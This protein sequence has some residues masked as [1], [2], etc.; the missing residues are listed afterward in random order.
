[1]MVL[2]N[3]KISGKLCWVSVDIIITFKFHSQFFKY[4]IVKIVTFF[5]HI[6][7]IIKKDILTTWKNYVQ[8]MEKNYMVWGSEAS[9]GKPQ[10]E[11][12][13]FTMSEDR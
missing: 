13:R 10:K 12:G 1:M 8:I 3:T 2:S 7:H 9:S 11:A 5:E 6:Y 4:S